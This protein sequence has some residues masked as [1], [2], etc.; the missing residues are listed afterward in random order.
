VWVGV[1]GSGGWWG[2]DC[3][4]VFDG[5]C[6]SWG[7]QGGQVGNLPPT[8][9]QPLPPEQPTCTALLHQHG[10]DIHA[11][12]GAVLTDGLAAQDGAVLR[13]GWGYGLSFG[14]GWDWLVGGS[15]C[16]VSGF[17]MKGDGT[18]F[19]ALVRQTKW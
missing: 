16:Q 19:W 13:L 10:D 12:L 4:W 11:L 2:C 5:V 9:P 17:R 7:V 14:W 1:V 18:G 6:K 8:K 3:E 15:G